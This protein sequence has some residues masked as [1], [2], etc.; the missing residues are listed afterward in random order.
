MKNRCTWV[1]D[2][3]AYIAYHDNE[4]GKIITDEQMLFN[5]LCL[6]TQMAGLSW[7]VVLKKRH[8][9]QRH[10]F[11]L[12]IA[13]IAT[14]SDDDILQKLAD[15]SLIRH[16][17][18]LFCLRQN[19]QVW[20]NLAQNMDM[21][22]YLHSFDCAQDMMHALKVHGFTFIGIITCQSFMHAVGIQNGHE[23]QCFLCPEIKN[24]N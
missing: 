22:R 5:A 21:V 2:D 20:Q 4:W 11:D 17:K 14:L 7:W 10:F 18:K 15:P 1:S 13:G 19:A 9:Y 12:G 6:E 16:R 23:P 3:P 24:K 8:A